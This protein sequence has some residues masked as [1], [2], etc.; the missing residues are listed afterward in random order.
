M[1]LRPDPMGWAF[2]FRMN[3]YRQRTTSAT[4]NPTIRAS[5]TVPC[6]G[7]TSLG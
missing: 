5:V 2:F 7:Q 3:R 1:G 4:T 6:Q